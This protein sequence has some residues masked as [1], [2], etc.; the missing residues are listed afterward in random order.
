MYDF[1]KVQ[2]ATAGNYIEPGLY[3]LR[4]KDAK[5]I[6]SKQN[7]TPGLA[8]TFHNK[9]GQTVTATFYVTEN[10]L[11]RLQYL[12]FA[13]LGKNADGTFKTAEAIIEYFVKALT[14]VAAKKITKVVLVGGN[15][16]ENGR[17]FSD[18]PYS[19][20][21]VED[22]NVELGEFD[23]DSKE[24]KKYVLPSNLKNESSG[25][26]NGILNNDDDDEDKEDEDFGKDKKGGKSKE[27]ETE[28]SKTTTK[29]TTKATGK[30]KKPVEDEE[31]DDTKG[32]EEEEEG[33]DDDLKW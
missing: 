30:G 1:S 3:K 7:K 4:I 31:E 18:L 23:K 8:V 15:I 19:G 13:W 25:K 2:P 28:K 29:T 5:G 27:K 11:D 24:Y 26:K 16:A 17:V 33:S 22:E 6:E 14:S 32:G 10:T 21:I 20:F 12:H 9:N